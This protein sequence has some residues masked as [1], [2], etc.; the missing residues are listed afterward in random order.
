[1]KEKVKETHLRFG[2]RV[3]LKAIVGGSIYGF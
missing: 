2:H 3:A 1:M